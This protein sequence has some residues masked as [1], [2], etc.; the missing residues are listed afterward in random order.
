MMPRFARAL[1]LWALVCAALG[2]V[3]SGA[4][5]AARSEESATGARPAAKPKCD[6]DGPLVYLQ[7]SPSGNS[8]LQVFTQQGLTFT[9]CYE[10]SLPLGYA[11]PIRVDQ[12]QNVWAVGSSVE[13]FVK[14]G[15]Q[16]ERTLTGAGSPLDIAVDT[17]GSVY[18]S[19]NNSTTIEVYAPGSNSPTSHLTAGCNGSGLA[20]DAQHDLYVATS[21]G[22]TAIDLTTG[23]RANIPTSLR[24]QWMQTTA[25][26]A[27]AG[28]TTGGTCGSLSSPGPGKT[29][30]WRP[31][32]RA[33]EI[34]G[35]VLFP[36]E[37]LALVNLYN[38]GGGVFGWPGPD[39]G[40]EVTIGDGSTE[41][42]WGVAVS[43]ADPFGA[44]FYAFSTSH[45]RP[46]RREN[47]P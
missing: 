44:P 42:P 12:A 46:G 36:G 38:T 41:V 45:G 13:E 26:G 40:Q 14:G 3:E 33:G 39:R 7:S 15:M 2:L 20:L 29:S 22:L 1:A 28:C 27:L 10:V 23:E 17:D 25:T 24:L 16:L 5:A 21:C 4:V 47:R 9:Y 30:T 31:I 32:F 11:F 8:S 18:L 35:F 19:Q 37:Q 43:P 34:E 6:L